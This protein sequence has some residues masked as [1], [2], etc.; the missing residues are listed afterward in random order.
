MNTGVI[1][2]LI[3]NEYIRL[4]KR[5]VFVRIYFFG[6]KVYSDEMFARRDKQ[7]AYVF[8]FNKNPYAT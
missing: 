8:I 3:E 5:V 6:K 2:L 4:S 7:K 1:F